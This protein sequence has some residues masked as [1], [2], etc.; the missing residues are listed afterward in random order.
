MEME[1]L[2]VTIDTKV[3]CRIDKFLEERAS[4]NWKLDN[5]PLNP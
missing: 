3:D 2:E 4:Y 1:L 5:D